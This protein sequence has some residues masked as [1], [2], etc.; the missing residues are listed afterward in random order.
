MRRLLPVYVA[1]ILAATL[2][3][4]RFGLPPYFAHQHRPA[5]VWDARDGMVFSGVGMFTSRTRGAVDLSPLAETDA[6]YL[7]VEAWPDPVQGPRRPAPLLVFA[8]RDAEPGLMLAQT[9]DAAVLRLPAPGPRPGTV[10]TDEIYLPGLL[11]PGRWHRLLVIE[12]GPAVRIWSDGVLVGAYARGPVPPEFWREGRYLAAG[13]DLLDWSGWRGR[14]RSIRIGAGAPPA[15][16]RMGTGAPAGG[17]QVAA[18]PLLFAVDAEL[19]VWPT[20]WA[21]RTG[22]IW[23]RQPPVPWSLKP[24]AT[25]QWL[26]A[27]LNILFFVPLGALARWRGWRLW[28][29]VLAGLGLSVGVESAQVFLERT[30]D[31]TDVLMNG[32]GACV[33]AAVVQLRLRRAPGTTPAALP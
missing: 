6:W 1:G 4:Y 24:F 14:I 8:R 18:A 32:T 2:Y 28:A 12:N 23:N 20:G 25:R 7:Y 21:P 27:G 31:V 5:P 33:G 10:R 22:D 9:G 13:N 3:P 15:E 29:V 26:D 17:T 16:L 30:C 11:A 19:S